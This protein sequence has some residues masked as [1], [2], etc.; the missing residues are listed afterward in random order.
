MEIL[1]AALG[2]NELGTFNFDLGE[3]LCVLQPFLYVVK[4]ELS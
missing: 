1:G 2:K 3:Y 4:F